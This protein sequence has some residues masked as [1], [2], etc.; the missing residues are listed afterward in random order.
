MFAIRFISAGWI[1]LLFLSLVCLGS[2]NAGE[3]DP[4]DF[5]NSL[6]DSG[7]SVEPLTREVCTDISKKG[8]AV[9]PVGFF[10]ADGWVFALYDLDTSPKFSLLD[11]NASKLTYFT[12]LNLLLLGR[13][14]PSD[15]IKASFESL[16]PSL[17]LADLGVFAYPLGLCLFLA[18]F[19]TLERLYCL[20]KGLTFPRKVE[21]ALIK[22]E[23]PDK[24][25]KKRSSAERIAWVAVHENPSRETLSSFCEMEIN[26]LRKG[27]FL[28]EIII[29]GAPLIGLLGTVTGLV[30]VF[31]ALPSKQ[32]VDSL[33]S[34]GIGMALLT[35]IAGLSIAIPVLAVHTYLS[36]II[37]KRE[38]SLN[39]LKDC[40]IDS[41]GLHSSKSINL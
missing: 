30:Q 20:R 32:G 26:A 37:E 3:L 13:G 22:G 9:S 35:T 38:T 14:N 40:L 28:L 25:W 17:G 29:S 36:R 18:C 21:K 8:P 4:K 16:Q 1:L 10:N 39:W 12:N 27:L 41:K 5:L 2:V 31:S 15:E 23:Y 11:S 24:K 7:I 33:F 6:K 34:D 19:V